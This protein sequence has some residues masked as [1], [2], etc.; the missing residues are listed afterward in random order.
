MILHAAYIAGFLDGDGSVSARLAPQ[1][2]GA[3]FAPAFIPL[4]GFYNQD[5]DVLTDL[6]ETLGCGKIVAYNTKGMGSGCYRLM[7]PLSSTKRVLELILPYLR[8]KRQQAQLVLAGLETKS[9]GSAKIT[10]EVQTLREAIVQQV[11]ALNK[12][13]GKAYRTKWVNSVDTSSPVTDEETIPSQAS[14]G[15]FGAEEGVTTSS[16]SPNNNRSHED[17]PRKGLYSLTSTVM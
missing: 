10:P 12:A 15:D 17:P 9:A 3:H 14:A 4:V 16:V 8:V 7:V 1:H 11:S 5:Y 13:N 6:Q 2:A